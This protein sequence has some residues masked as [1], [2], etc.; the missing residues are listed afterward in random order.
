MAPSTPPIASYASWVRTAPRRCF[1]SCSSKNERSGKRPGSWLTSARIR[2]DKSRLEL[3]PHLGRG[4]L[5]DLPEFP[6]VHG[7]Q[8]DLGPFPDA[9]DQG[10]IVEDA[11]VEIRPAC[12]DDRHGGVLRGVE[13]L[14]DE[15][16]DDLVFRQSV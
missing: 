4:C 16:A 6:F 7:T 8:G 13:Q 14:V 10:A 9:V 2:F 11:A 3:Q 12:E 5:D 1:Q 15:G